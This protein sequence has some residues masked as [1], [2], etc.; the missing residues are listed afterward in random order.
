M[1]KLFKDL[2]DCNGDRKKYR[3]S[4]VLKFE[5]DREYYLFS[6]LPTIIWSPW[7]YRLKGYYVL[8]IWWLYFHIGFGKWEQLSCSNCKHQ[9]ECVE[10]KRIKW[11]S[12]DVFE[13]GEKCS[14]FESR[15]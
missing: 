10:S 5:V 14:D 11:Y 2:K 7:I 3:I 15:Y 6:F 13:Q 8:D 4:P 9:N 12:D 1:K